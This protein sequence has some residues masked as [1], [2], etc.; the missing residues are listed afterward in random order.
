MIL[1][2]LVFRSHRGQ[3][4]GIWLHASHLVQGDRRVTGVRILNIL[5]AYDALI[6]DEAFLRGKPLHIIAQII[7]A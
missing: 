1:L 4:S 2:L 7:T 5:F 6:A 3:T